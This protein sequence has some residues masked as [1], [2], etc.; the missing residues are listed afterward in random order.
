MNKEPQPSTN[1]EIT[2]GQPQPGDSE[3]IRPILEAWIQDSET[4]EP[5]HEEI[6]GVIDALEESIE[7]EG[8]KRYFVARDI[9]GRVLGIVGYAQPSSI[10]QEFTNTDNP[11]ELINAYVDPESRGMGVGTKLVDALED[12]A[13]RAGYTEVILNSGPR[14]RDSG[15]GFYQRRYG[16]PSAVAKDL[17]RP[18]LDAPVWTHTLGEEL[19]KIEE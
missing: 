13:L 8:G 7:G 4:G 6:S 5:I 9:G 17:Y 15:H 3:A 18:D 1:T 16:E 14:Y 11:V 2:I 12:D 19:K 10:M